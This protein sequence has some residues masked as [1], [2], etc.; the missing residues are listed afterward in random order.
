M[1]SPKLTDFNTFL[2]W[3]NDSSIKLATSTVVKK[4]IANGKVPKPVWGEFIMN[5]GA[6]DKA[7]KDRNSIEG[8]FRRLKKS[9]VF[10]V[11]GETA[12]VLL[13]NFDMS[14]LANKQPKQKAFGKPFP[15]KY[16]EAIL[17]HAYQ[18]YGAK[19][20]D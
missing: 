12:E 16:R 11:G 8:E 9:G 2:G 1:R 20:I 6:Y 10:V 4:V 13:N 18:L 7:V 17:R 5:A 19:I 14:V 15:R 3:F